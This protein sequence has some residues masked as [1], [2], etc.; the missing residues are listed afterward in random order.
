[1]LEG[2]AGEDVWRSGIR[3]YV[4]KHAYANTKTDDL[5]MAV[6]A[7][8]AA[9]LTKIAHDFTKQPGVPLITVGPVRCEGGNSK[10]TLTQGEFSRDRKAE[11]DAKP[12]SWNVPVIAQTTGNPAARTIVSGGTA[13]MSVAGCST[14]LVNAGQSGYY[15]VRYQPE[16]VTALRGDFAKLP[17][18]DQ[19]GLLSDSR[20]LSHNGYQDMDVALSMIDAVP[21]SAS[22]RVVEQAV[23]EFGGMFELLREDKPRQT[24]LAAIANTRFSPALAKLGM[25]QRPDELAVD[26]NLR[27]SL[28]G[29]LG[30]MENSAVKAEAARLFAAL[31]S[32]PTALDGPLRTTWLGLIAYNADKATWDSIR[33]LAQSSDN[34]VVQSTMYRLLGSAKDKALAADA[35]K[36]ALTAEPGATTSAS[37][38]GAVAGEHP[39]MAADFA[40]ANREAVLALVDVGSRSEFVAKLA[41]GSEDPAMPAKLDQYAKSH[42]TPESRKTVDEAIAAINTRLKTLPR[43]KAGIAKWIDGKQ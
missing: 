29:T 28:L 4:K 21:A 27:S 12:L 7:A 37:I 13:E 1:M 16:Q 30:F 35:L 10:F 23:G 31:D 3:A 34:T 9:G 17:A 40:L 11:T 20:S 22:Q 25:V 41:Y 42:L 5:W 33:K 2:F 36:L 15:R 32:N 26:S 19:S 14:L 6:E 18:L 8:G 38:I 39:D 43:V 24:K